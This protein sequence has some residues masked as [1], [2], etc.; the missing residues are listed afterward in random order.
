MA[1]KFKLS[2]TM[3]NVGAAL[4]GRLPEHQQMKLMQQDAEMAREQQLL[5][6]DQQRRQALVEDARAGLKLLQQG[7]VPAF[8]QLGND[9]VNYIRSL[10][11][12]PTDTLGILQQVQSGNIQGAMQ[13]LQTVVDMA[14]AYAQQQAPQI[15]DANQYQGGQMAMFDPNTGQARAVPVEGYTPQAEKID[16]NRPFL[17]DGT[18]NSQYQQY[19]LNRSRAGGTNVT[20]GQAT[21]G[22]RNAGSLAGR[23][24]FAQSQIN[25]VLAQNPDAQEPGLLPTFLS[26][27]G[28]DYL[29]N[30]TNP[31][32]R[33]IIEAAQDDMLDAALTISTGAAYTKQ[34]F[35]SYKRSLF[36]QLNDDQKTREAKQVRLKNFIEQAYKKAGRAAPEEMRSAETPGVSTT[37]N[38][39]DLP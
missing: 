22:E 7:N 1:E 28:F 27:A 6:L 11:G 14:D 36:P 32:D 5:A 8:M 33:Q 19:E 21:E 15:L 20:V 3:G 35:D 13:E 4:Q 25:D 37:I 26:K 24:D 2:E 9:R 29:A 31:A 38:W 12:D 10:K 30:I 34:Q 39:A 23:L 17:P 18:P 16:Y